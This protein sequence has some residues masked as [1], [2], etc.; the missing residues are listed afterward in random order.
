MVNIWTIF[1]QLAGSRCPLCHRPG[2]GFCPTC[3]AALP[4]NTLSC[5]SCALPLP[6]GTP[7]GILCAGCQ[8][9]PPAFDRVCAPLRYGAPVDDLIAA[10]KYHGQLAQGRLLAGMLADAV[11]A[12]EAPLPA[13]LLPVPMHRIALRER[14]FNQATELTR[15]VAADLDLAWSATNLRRLRHGAHQRGLNRADRQ[16]NLRDAF[17][18]RGRLPGHVALIDDVVTTA[19]TAHEIART[20]RHSGVERVEVWAVARTPAD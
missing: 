3:R 15:L 4:H 12:A 10:F 11:R 17:A 16:R 5:R 19:A 9:C 1:D 6:P 7:D 8:R 2:A 14:G 18:V 20:L 13:L